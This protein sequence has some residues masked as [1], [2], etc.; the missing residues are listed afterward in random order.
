[1]EVIS[2]QYYQNTFS[3][4]NTF[5]WSKNCK[6]SFSASQNTLRFGK[7]IFMGKVQHFHGQAHIFNSYSQLGQNTLRFWQ[8]IIFMGKQIY[9]GYVIILSL[10]VFVVKMHFAL[11]I[12][13]FVMVKL[14]NS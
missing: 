4:T 14:M 7:N 10:S 11:A 2:G 3:W 1:M 12:T 9:M 8:T 6:F 13:E 5:L